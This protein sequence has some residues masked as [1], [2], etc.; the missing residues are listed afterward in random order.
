MERGDDDEDLMKNRWETRVASSQ[1][2]WA[3]YRSIHI[4]P[5][6]HQSFVQSHRLLWSYPRS[7]ER[8]WMRCFPWLLHHCRLLSDEATNYRSRRR[9]LV[10]TANPQNPHRLSAGLSPHEPLIFESE[11]LW[12]IALSPLSVA[13]YKTGLPVR[14]PHHFTPCSPG[15]PGSP[16]SPEVLLLRPSC[17]KV[18]L[19]IRFRVLSLHTFSLTQYLSLTLN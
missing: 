6:T 11:N 12:N 8:M 10:S 3:S 19:F 9:R 14:K 2:F 7:Y 17:I 15:S 16:G 13:N 18:D 5:F 1:P 4:P